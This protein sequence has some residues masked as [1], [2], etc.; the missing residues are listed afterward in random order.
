MAAGLYSFLFNVFH[1]CIFLKFFSISLS[2]F[3]IFN[4][5]LFYICGYFSCLYVCV[6]MHMYAAPIESRRG[7]WSYGT[8]VTDDY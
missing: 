7:Q 1:Y 5:F 2:Y 6:C 4:L 8:E 3:E